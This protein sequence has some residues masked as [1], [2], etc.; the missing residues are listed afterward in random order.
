MK[1]H[2]NCG[3]QID[4]EVGLTKPEVDSNSNLFFLYLIWTFMD[5][6]ASWEAIQLVPSSLVL[7]PARV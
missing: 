1:L 7:E 3:L 5:G 2:I 4:L 6:A